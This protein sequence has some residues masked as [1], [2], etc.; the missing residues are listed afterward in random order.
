METC[1]TK[2]V[3]VVLRPQNKK[4]RLGNRRKNT[5]YRERF[6]LEIRNKKYYHG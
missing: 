5:E 6:I 4:Q 1:T 3:S 2:K